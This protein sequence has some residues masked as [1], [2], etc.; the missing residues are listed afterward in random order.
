[1][2]NPLMRLRSLRV[3]D[4]MSTEMVNVD[5]NDSIEQASRILCQ[6]KHS[7]APV[8][9]EEGRCVGILSATDFLKRE[10]EVAGSW[11]A[12]DDFEA[13]QDPEQ[14]LRVERRETDYVRDYMTTAPQTVLPS[15]RLMKAAEIMRGVHVHRLP[16]LDESGRPIG[17]VSSMDVVSALLN[18][19]DEMNV[20]HFTRA[21]Q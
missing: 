8:V 13:R 15:T 19:V 2:S 12:G 1:M 4:V 14:M 18:V 16:V 5:V 3:A 9:D 10:C 17:V 6:H 21:R 20:E 7:A 11:L